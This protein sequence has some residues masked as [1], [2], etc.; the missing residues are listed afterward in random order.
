MNLDNQAQLVLEYGNFLA[1]IADIH[2]NNNNVNIENI[3]NKEKV[4]GTKRKELFI[5]LSK[6]YNKT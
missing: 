1:Q 5:S 6:A 2:P 3:N 4:L